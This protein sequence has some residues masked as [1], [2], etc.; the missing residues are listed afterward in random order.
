MRSASELAV[1]GGTV[2]RTVLGTG[3]SFFRY[4]LGRFIRDGCL[5][6]AGALSY[7]TLL[8]LVPLIAIIFAVLSAFP[9][10]AATRDQ[11]LAGLFGRSVPE[12][13]AGDGLLVPSLRRCRGARRRRSASSPS[14]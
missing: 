5:T 2:V 9:T 11:L 3:L 1:A 4:T 12:V 8:S 14:P 6:A 10:F 7:A 13:G